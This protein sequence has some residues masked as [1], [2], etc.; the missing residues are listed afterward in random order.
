MLQKLIL[1][2]AVSTAA[3]VC[4]DD[5]FFLAEDGMPCTSWASMDCLDNSLSVL[6]KTRLL[7]S[8]QLAC[9]SCVKVRPLCVFLLIF[10]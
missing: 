10:F 6:G 4:V 1:A 9:D 8:C 7:N 5:P 2:L 3:G